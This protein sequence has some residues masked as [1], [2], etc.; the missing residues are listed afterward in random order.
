MTRSP[1]EWKT[2]CT[3]I[4]SGSVPTGG[5]E[6]TYSSGVKYVK[7][8]LRSRNIIKAGMRILEIGSGNGRVAMGLVEDDVHYTGLEPILAS[9]EFCREAFAEFPRFTFK[10]VDV[11][12]SF[13][14]PTGNNSSESYRLPI[15]DNAF[16]L[17][18]AASVFTHLETDEAAKNYLSCIHRALNRDG[19]MFST[20]FRSPPNSISTTA[21]RTVYGEAWI[22][23]E[24]SR[25]F[26][27]AE[28]EHGTTTAYHDQWE[29]VG[30]KRG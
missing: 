26:D 10:H 24:V 17:V 3:G 27:I 21:E 7:L 14:N 18:I 16:D 1:D 4:T 19:I 29:I 20:W 22:F 15:P 6:V 5:K 12:N 13:Y 23:S 2:W 9:V 30:R 25:Y 8:K 11:R 28:S